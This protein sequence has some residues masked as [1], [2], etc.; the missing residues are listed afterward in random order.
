MGHNVLIWRLGGEEK[1]AGGLY[2]PE[3]H[4]EV[5]SRGI[6]LSTG[7]AAHDILEDALIEVGDEVCFSHWAGRDRETKER[8]AGE[9]ASKILECKAE[10]ILGS[11]DALERL[12]DYT[13]DLDD[14][15]NT[16]YVKKGS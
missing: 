4:R 16:I 2:V 9:K 15:G 6:L 14:D 1:T 8:T 11:V 12:K 13:T 10:D 3:E 7:L 5:K